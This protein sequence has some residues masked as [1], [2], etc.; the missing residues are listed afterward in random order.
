MHE[1]KAANIKCLHCNWGEI[2]ADEQCAPAS[3][4]VKVALFLTWHLLDSASVASRQE[5]T[6]YAYVHT[7]FMQDRSTLNAAYERALHRR[8]QNVISSSSFRLS[9]LLSP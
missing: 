4:S 6:V 8:V 2:G 1:N 5:R 3:G 9:A 7:L